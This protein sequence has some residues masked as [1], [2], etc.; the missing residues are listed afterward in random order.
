MAMKT[1]RIILQVFVLFTILSNTIFAQPSNVMKD[2]VKLSYEDEIST[3]HAKRIEA[4][5][6]PQ[7]WLSLVA[8]NWL[9][10]GQNRLES[11][12]TLTLSKGIVTFQVLPGVQANIGSDEFT[13]GVLKAEGG[14]ERADRVEIGSRVLTIIKRGERFAVRMWD[15]NAEA[16]KEFKGIERFPVSKRW[17]IEARWEPYSSPKAIK[18]A[19]VIPGYLED[20]TVPGVAVFFIG[21]REYKLEPVGSGSETLFFIFADE[22]NGKESYGAGRFLYSDPAKDGKV[23]IDFNKA[24]NPP[25]A[26]TPYATCPLPPAS[27]SLPVRIE[28][29]EKSFGD[30]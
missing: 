20:Y 22:T 24:I 12:G 11:L 10:E 1:T 6:R 30:H 26:F 25:C 23:I 16:L 9:N 2:S 19:S 28:A 17:R 21:G 7:G 13:S 14:K 3:W 5:K 27:N 18:V 29:G 15:S 4:L 8:L